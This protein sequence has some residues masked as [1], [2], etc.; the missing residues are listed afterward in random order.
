LAKSAHKGPGVLVSKTPRSRGH[1]TA[2]KKRRVRKRAG[3]GLIGCEKHGTTWGST[4]APRE[5]GPAKGKVHYGRCKGRRRDVKQKKENRNMEHTRMLVIRVPT[6][7]QQVHE[8][9]PTTT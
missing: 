3:Y 2:K 8:G 7:K 1:S 5:T 9:N 4:S 6:T